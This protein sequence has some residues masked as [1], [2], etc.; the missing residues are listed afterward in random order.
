MT[1][2]PLTSIRG[3]DVMRGENVKVANGLTIIIIHSR[4]QCFDQSSMGNFGEFKERK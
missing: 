1:E 2:A 3:G 4:D